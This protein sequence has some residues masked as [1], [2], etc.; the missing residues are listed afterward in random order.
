MRFFEIDIRGCDLQVLI[1]VAYRSV[2][3]SPQLLRVKSTII[4]LHHATRIV[5]SGVANGGHGC[6][7]LPIVDGN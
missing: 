6:M 3:K 2:N 4:I 5:H 1:I 7:S